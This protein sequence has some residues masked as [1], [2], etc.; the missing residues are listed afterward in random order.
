MADVRPARVFFR[1]H[2]GR[3]LSTRRCGKRPFPRQRPRREPSPPLRARRGVASSTFARISSAS[4]VSKIVQEMVNAYKRE[5]DSVALFV[6]EENYIP[7]K[8]KN[9]GS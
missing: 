9:E 1:S 6:E 5:S 7:V 3:A 2:A 8:T 4:T